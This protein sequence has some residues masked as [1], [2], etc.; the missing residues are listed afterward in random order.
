M[1]RLNTV[2]DVAAWRM[3]LGCGAC[4]YICPKQAVRLTDVLDEGIRPVVS[5]PQ[6]C[7]SC[8]ECLKVCPGYEND[9][10]E[11]EQRP[12]IIPELSQY[13]G[14]VLEI[15]EGHATDP[16]IRFAGS[17]GGAITALSLYCLERAGMHGVLHIGL[18]PDD[19]IRNQTRMSFSRQDLLRATGSRYAPASA[20]DSLG[21]I[22]SAPTPCVFVGQPSEVTA[23]RKAQELKPALDRNV[24]LAISFFCAGSPSSRGT[25]ELLKHL[26]IN[27]AEVRDLR[28]RGNGWPGNF[29]V[30]RAG[31]ESPFRQISYQESWNILQSFR[32]YSTHLW[33]DGSG[34]DAD[35]SC[36]DPWY[37]PI[38]PGEAGS[39][40]VVVRTELGRKIVRAAMQAGYL[41]LTVADPKKLLNSQKNLTHK[42]RMI[43]GRRLAFHA[44]GL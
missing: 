24:G 15:W 34:E 31:D 16:E 38:Q 12:G 25:L 9:H 29:A 2:A 39:S 6:S 7:G 30:S 13:C 41:S 20:C 33:P 19:P 10:S 32:P 28:Y 5:D 3:C 36:G 21:L 37:R 1:P 26:G 17:S 27:A 42:R 11:L 18:N 4:A 23:L 44:F 43:W 8:N 35:I 22:E 14:P 40:L